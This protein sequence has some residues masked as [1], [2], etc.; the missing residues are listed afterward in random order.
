MF[1]FCLIL[2]HGY[3]S[4]VY[5]CNFGLW[6]HVLG[7]FIHG[8]NQGLN[9]WHILLEKSCWLCQDRFPGHLSMMISVF[10]FLF[11]STI[12]VKLQPFKK[13]TLHRVVLILNPLLNRPKVLSPIVMQL[14]KLKPL[15]YWDWQVPPSS[16]GISISLLLWFWVFSLFSSPGD[17]LLTRSAIHLK[18]SLL[19]Y[20]LYFWLLCTGK[21]SRHFSSQPCQKSKSLPFIFMWSFLIFFSSPFPLT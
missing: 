11:F 8:K 16:C 9:L 19:H 17:L 3:I 21:F 4:P 10:F 20:S 2:D 13:S 14:L 5:F 1:C 18:G 7:S 6:T 15:A 12:L